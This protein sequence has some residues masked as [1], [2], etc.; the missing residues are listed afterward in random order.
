MR[1]R[2]GQEPMHH[3]PVAKSKD[4][5]KKLKPKAQT[6]NCSAKHRHLGVRLRSPLSPG[7]SGNTGNKKHHHE[8]RCFHD[9]SNRLG[10]ERCTVDPLKRVARHT[11]K[12]KPWFAEHGEMVPMSGTDRGNTTVAVAESNDTLHD[13]SLRF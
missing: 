7:T 9:L 3:L 8:Q 5:P 10:Y 1:G 6:A 2:E 11:I 4:T 13:C 12:A